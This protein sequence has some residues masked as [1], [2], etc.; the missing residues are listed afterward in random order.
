MSVFI[1][2]RDGGRTPVDRALLVKLAQTRRLEPETTLEVDGVSRLA[3]ELS[4]LA[5]IFRKL[6]YEEPTVV[7]T[8]PQVGEPD[9]GAT[10]QS[11][12][13]SEPS[14]K[15][16]GSTLT[17]LEIRRL[18]AKRVVGRFRSDAFSRNFAI[19]ATFLSIVY[20]FVSFAVGVAT[21]RSPE[22]WTEQFYRATTL[23][24]L[25]AFYFGI[26]RAIRTSAILR[27]EASI[28]QESRLREENR[29]E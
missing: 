4:E 11:G 24:V 7:P 27:E 28:R 22:G 16:D 5:P 29:E 15:S 6:G 19:S 14:E 20:A 2:H 23:I 9:P 17:E 1:V 8:P 13:F 25:F 21:R 26:V 3:R 10:S 18:A 12:T